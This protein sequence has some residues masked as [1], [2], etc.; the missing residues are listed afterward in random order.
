VDATSGT[1]AQASISAGKYS[2]STVTIEAKFNV[3]DTSHLYKLQQKCEDQGSGTPDYRYCTLGIPATSGYTGVTYYSV[4]SINC[5][6]VDRS[7]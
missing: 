2:Q 3:N 6:K 5:F 1:V 7:M 4:V